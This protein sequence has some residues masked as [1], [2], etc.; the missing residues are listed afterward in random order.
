MFEPG[1]KEVF[2]SSIFVLYTTLIIGGTNQ[3]FQRQK[4][5]ELCVT[6]MENL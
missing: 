2:R 3:Q 6:E 1:I 5:H 4:V